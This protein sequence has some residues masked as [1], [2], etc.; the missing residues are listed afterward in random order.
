MSDLGTPGTSPAFSAPDAVRRVGL[1]VLETD[2]TMERDVARLLHG[3]GLAVHANRI[4]FSNPVSA[5]SLAA[6]ETSLSAA[7]A[8]LIPGTPFDVIHFGCTSAS[9]VIGDDG[10]SAAVR[11]AKP[12][13][14]AT[15]PIIAADAALKALGV[16]RLSILTPY[17]PEIARPVAD[18]FAALG[19]DI[20][21]L[22]CWAIEDDRD[23]ARVRPDV[24]IREAV[25]ATDPKADA[26]FIS[27][28]AVSAAE[29]VPLIEAEVDCPVVTSNQAAAWLALRLCGID[30]DV[31]GGGRL[32]S[33]PLAPGDRKGTA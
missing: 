21:G 20:A 11:T 29:V 1:V 13:A 6:L 12:G 27:C 15:N 31:P 7:T 2:L 19:Y 9:A 30:H 8:A 4:A 25:A 32:F 17:V 18:R 22:T 3:S 14:R 24:L 26:L 23:M 10:V 28:T 16:R 5:E 33:R